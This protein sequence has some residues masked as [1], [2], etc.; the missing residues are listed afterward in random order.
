MIYLNDQINIKF[1]W[2]QIKNE[3]SQFYLL[4]TQSIILYFTA[5]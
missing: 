5:I 3:N 1:L 2:D 4:I